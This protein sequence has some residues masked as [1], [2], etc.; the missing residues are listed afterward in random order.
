MDVLL[1]DVSEGDLPTFFEHQLDPAAYDMAAFKPRDKNAFT[2][3]WARILADRTVAKKTILFDGYVVGYI[4]SFER[5]AQREIGYWIDREYWGRGIATRALGQFLRHF[6]ERPLYALVA[7]HN[8]ASVRV[9][10]KCGF[11][12]VGQ[13]PGCPDA[14]G[15]VVEEL[16]LKLSGGQVQET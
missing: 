10:E 11:A 2:E 8:A 6:T 9:L 16:T 1:R 7:K 3:H 15:P 13:G 14:R 5:S 4:V 12:V